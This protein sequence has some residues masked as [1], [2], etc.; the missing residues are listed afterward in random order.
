MK[1][2]DIEDLYP[3][4]PM[5]QGMLFESLYAGDSKVY[6]EQ[7]SYLLRGYL[8]VAA[9]ERAW[10]EVMDRH[11]VLRTSFVWED[12]DEPVQVVHRH[13]KLPLQLQDW[14]QFSPIQQEQSLQDYLDENRRCGFD[15]S[16]APLM[17]FSLLRLADEDYRLIWSYHHSLLDG[18]SWPLLVNEVLAFYD[19]YSRKQDLHL[20]NPRPYRDYIAWLQQQD[21][22]R[23]EAFWRNKL[24]GFGAP[25][26]LGVDK[27]LGTL[28]DAQTRADLEVRLSRPLTAALSSMAK[29]NQVTLNTLVQ[30]VWALLLSHYSGEQ[31]VVFGT[32]FSG[33]SADLSGSESMIG[34]FINTLPVRVQVPYEDSVQ[35]Y[36]KQL[37]SQLAEMLLYEHNSLIQIQGWSE[38]PRGLRLFESILAFDNYPVDISA[39]KQSGRPEI[40]NAHFEHE[41]DTTFGLIVA[42]GP[43]LLLHLIY[44]SRRFDVEMADRMMGHFRTLC[45]NIAADPYQRLSALQLLSPAETQQLLYDWNDTGFDFAAPECLH[46]LF[47]AQA[48]RSPE[49]TAVVF[50]A[51]EVTYRELNGKANQLA[52][53]LRRLGV[54]L[55]VRVGL[56]LERSPELVIAVLAVL[57]AGGA[58]VPLDLNAPLARVAQMI[59]EAGIGVVLTQEEV[60]ERL[61]ASW[62]Q[63]VELDSQW[64]E[65]SG[66]SDELAQSGVGGDNLAYVIF[67]SGSTGQ[68]K[69]VMVQHRSVC[70]IILSQIRAFNVHRKTRVLQFASLSFDASVPEIFTALCAGAVVCLATADAMMPGSGLTQLLRTM[71]ITNVTFPPSVLTVLPDD[72]LPAL[73]T[74]ISAGESCTPNIVERWAGGRLFINGY[75]PTEGTVGVAINTSVDKELSR[76]VGRPFPNVQVYILNKQLRP[77]PVRVAGEIFI[78]G[79]GLAR[80][81][82][83]EPELTAERFI[84]H[85][86]TKEPNARLYRTG[87]LGRYLPDG[88]MEILGRIDHQVKIRGY[89]VEPGEIEVALKEHPAVRDGVVIAREDMPGDK[90]LV[91]YVV[92][93]RKP[94]ESINGEPLYRL[95]NNVAIAHLNKNETDTIYRQIFEN[96]SYL[97]H[98]IRLGADSCVF[99]VGANI[100]LFS[101]FVKLRWPQARVYAFEPVPP[102]F[103]KLRTNALLHD[104]NVKLFAC[105]LS[106]EL[107]RASVTYYPKMSA[108]SGVYANREMDERTVR[109]YPARQDGIAT[110]F[111]DELLKGQFHSETFDCELKRLSD[112]MN[113]HEIERID[114][115][116]IDVEKS[117]L[118]VLEGVD[119]EDWKKIKQIVVE[120]HDLNGRV[121]RVTEL[122][123]THGFSVS[124]DQEEDLALSG[125]YNIYA[126]G[127]AEGEEFSTE[128]LDE[129]EG[130]TL[131]ALG[132]STV[133][134]EEL[135][136]FLKERLPSYMVP[137]AFVLLEQLPLMPSGKVNRKALPAPEAVHSEGVVTYVAPRTAIE[138]MVAAMWE[139]I[140]HV[141]RVGIKDNFFD[142]GGHSLLATQFISRVRQEFQVDLPLS[143]LFESPTVADCAYAIA[144]N[145]E[146]SEMLAELENLPDAEVKVLLAAEE[147]LTRE[148]H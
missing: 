20:T 56:Y 22:S 49:A 104:L 65:I 100:G 53:Y 144:H 55:E 138:R 38:V 108:M 35:S 18:W 6:V 71:A 70:N 43:E 12:L 130:G 14:R 120:V 91:A 45:A 57:K 85:P 33:R 67:T 69:G 132:N 30:G 142:L 109:D 7:R 80:G 119:E 3:L 114:L 111:A 1:D 93:D 74:I 137:S 89:R 86:F 2:P 61:P 39:E 87:D 82:L 63:V 96:R 90:R 124:V 112:V 75:G 48:E 10:Q 147:N 79:I 8:N 13:V 110:E 129:G 107:K 115:L 73:E 84:P 23:A 136:I 105:G 34:L 11:P 68:P 28:H 143:S 146:I 106:N 123:K 95:P 60:S 103:E 135:R 44:D 26:P 29:N 42:P 134:V 17:R 5:Q 52:H 117:E 21:V 97:K 88:R 77:A 47:E 16:E 83:N 59:S 64:G 62:L 41:V 36:L 66:E 4:S 81:Y 148:G 145:D 113:E 46:Q 133:T 126:K 101:L 58:Y 122:L 99:D 98:G 121:T 27:A 50:E 51:Q 54:G 92:T 19:A 32:V 141:E 118:D 25:T 125:L 72:D 24:K 127:P 116:K 94:A 40:R 139:E 128:E 15:L 78:G 31:D 102:L 140:L 37:Q 131:S 76:C 9:F